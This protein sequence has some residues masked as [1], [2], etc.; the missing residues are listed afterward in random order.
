MFE[1]LKFVYVMIFFISLFCFLN[2]VIA[3]DYYSCH[4][5]KQCDEDCPFP[6][7]GYCVEQHC[8][9]KRWLQ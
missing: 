1:I 9:C 2:G 7:K 4:Y 3:G 8:L 5:D 6:F